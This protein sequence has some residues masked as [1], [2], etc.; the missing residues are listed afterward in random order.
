MDDS[1]G[2]QGTRVNMV[3]SILHYGTCTCRKYM[4]QVYCPISVWKS[5]YLLQTYCSSPPKKTKTV[6]NVCQSTEINTSRA[7]Y[8]KKYSRFHLPLFEQ[9]KKKNACYLTTLVNW[10]KMLKIDIARSSCDT[11]SSGRTYI[12]FF[13]YMQV[14]QLCREFGEYTVWTTNISQPVWCHTFL[15]GW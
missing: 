13:F 9:I 11:H 1:S 3:N 4:Q 14:N 10:Y 2:T 8:L 6:I 12:P 7:F 15:W 5:H